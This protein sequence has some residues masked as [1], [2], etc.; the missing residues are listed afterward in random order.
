MHTQLGSR[1]VR[2]LC[3]PRKRNK[4]VR[5]S[6]LISPFLKTFISYYSKEMSIDVLITEEQIC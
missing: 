1:R 6:E 2:D 3:V 4:P 5:L